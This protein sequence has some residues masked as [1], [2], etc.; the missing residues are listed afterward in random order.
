MARKPTKRE[1]GTGGP[2]LLSGG[3]PQIAKG[4]GHA[5]VEIYLDAM[6]GWKQ[7]V[8]RQVDSLAAATVPGLAKAVKWNSPLYGRPGA[9]QKGPWFMS[10]HCMTRY[11]KVAFF[12]GALLAPPPP[13]A[14]KHERVRYLDICEN[15]VIDEARLSD[16]IRQAA[17]LPGERM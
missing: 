16:W 14:S 1:T 3:N 9:D 12:D 11:V 6:P 4:F 17:R 2:E 13:G 5:V 10:F 15:D 7:R 8:G